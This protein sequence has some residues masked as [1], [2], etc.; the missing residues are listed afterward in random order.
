MSKIT[1]MIIKQK[2][3]NRY[4]K[5]FLGVSK[6]ILKLSPHLKEDLEQMDLD[7]TVEQYALA[8][9]INGFFLGFIASFL[10]FLLILTQGN[11]FIKSIQLF[12]LL[13]LGMSFL[14]IFVLMRYPK[15]EAGKKA[16]EVDKILLYSLRDLW[17]QVSSGISLYSAMTNI[18][19][20]KY[21]LVSKEFGVAVRDINRGLSIEK[22]LE[23]MAYRTRSEY[24]K[25]TLWQLV[26]T[27]KTGASVKGALGTIIQ[28]LSRTQR[29]KIKEYAQELNLW[30]LLYM[31]F[32]VAIPSIGAALL[33]VLSSFAQFQVTQVS[34]VSFILITVIIQILLI[35]FI[36]SR[37]PLAGF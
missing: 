6:P 1:L 5:D 34:F 30:T 4:F 37:R 13:F 28:D 26:N 9:T 14:F 11:T 24:L 16:E 7:V 35:G 27:L 15:I 8:S 2:T 25:R 31:L 17:L 10:L 23:K 33:V 20:A 12:A 21:G 22:A 29:R 18:S 3:V 36:K 32:S 19:N